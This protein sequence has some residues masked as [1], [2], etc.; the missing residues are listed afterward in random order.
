MGG[1]APGPQSG[2]RPSVGRFLKMMPSRVDE[3]ETLLTENR[4]WIGRTKGIGYISAEDAIA[5]SMSG[6]TIRAAGVAYDNRKAF[7]YSSY[8]EFDFD[9]PTRTESDCYARY[10]IRVAE[11]RESLKIVRQAMDKITDEGPIKAEAP[12]IIPPEREKMKTEME[13]LIY[14]F[15][16]FTEGFS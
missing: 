7:P 15:K 9:V 2:R 6:P 10:L 5:M 16:I 3:Y 14:H 13:A 12:G 1:V 11:M 8:E 4:I